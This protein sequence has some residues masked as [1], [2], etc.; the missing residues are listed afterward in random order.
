[1]TSA[2]LVSG[3]GKQYR[4]GAS[5]SGYGTLRDALAQRFRPAPQA[6]GTIWALRDVSFEVAQGEALGLIGPNGAGKTTLLKI[7]SRIT[8]PS[9][10]EA[11]IRGR[12]GSLLEVGTGFHPELTGRENV[13]L[14]GAILGMR[15][16]EIERRFDAIIAFAEVERFVDTPVKRYSTG[17]GVRLAF[18]IAAHLEPDVLLVDEVLAVGDASFQAKCL[19]KMGEVSGEGRTVLLVSHNMAAMATF[20]ERCIWLDHGGVVRD[21]PA[22]DV[23]RSY[24]E[25]SVA[26]TGGEVDLSP[27]R[28]VS[29]KHHQE[30]RFS[31]VRLAGPD[32]RARSRFFEG[33][34]ITIE[35]EFRASRPA[36]L[37]ELR[38]YVKSFMGTPLFSV[39]SGA[40][41]VDVSPGLW[42][43]SAT[44][45]PNHLRQGRYVVGLELTTG[46]LQDRVDE[47]IRFEVEPSLQGAEDPFLRRPEAGL[48][49]FDYSW[50]DPVPALT[51]PS[52]PIH[53]SEHVSANVP[54]GGA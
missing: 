37:V 34:P 45:D 1:M 25:A 9:R 28:P 50:N 2:I 8:D 4:L 17:M 38:A 52:M 12:V 26:D 3:L 51:E 39:V 22:P 36:H 31:S 30:L 47:A 43:A 21:G 20:A 24:V 32:D 11:R 54:G 48:F 18:A 19:G 42:R 44:I 7:L 53:P 10:G 14:N 40:R 16:R 29:S 49:H 15:R 5:T 13:Y 27:E 35:A 41:T 46:M 33:E 23:I 6:R